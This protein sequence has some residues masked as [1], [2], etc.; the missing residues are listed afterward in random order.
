MVRTKVFNKVKFILKDADLDML[1]PIYNSILKHMKSKEKL[2]VDI[3]QYWTV[4]R[5]WVRET[6]NTKCG[7]VNGMMKAAFMSKF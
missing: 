7:A 1:G 6:L 5:K 2:G 4:H 3:E